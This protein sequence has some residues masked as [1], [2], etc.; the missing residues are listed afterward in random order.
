MA[1]GTPY[2]LG[3]ANA[4][5]GSATLQLTVTATS[6]QGDA[7]V[8]AAAINSA[9]AQ[10]SPSACVDSQG[11][12][13]ALAVTTGLTTS[14]QTTLFVATENST[15]GLTEVLASGTD[16]IT[17]T[18]STSTAA[19]GRNIAAMGCSGVAAGPASSTADQTA[20]NNGGSAGSTTPAATLP[21]TAES[22]ELVVCAVSAHD[23]ANSITW[24]SPLANVTAPVVNA[25]NEY[26][27]VSAAVSTTAASTAY[28][29]TIITGKWDCALVSLIPLAASPAATLVLPPGF[30]SPAAFAFAPG[31]VLPSAPQNVNDAPV[32]NAPYVIGQANSGAITVNTITVK[33]QTPMNPGDSIVVTGGG[34][35]G[36][37]DGFSSVTDTKGNTYTRYAELANANA[38]Q[39]IAVNATPLGQ[40][41]TITCN[42]VRTEYKM[43]VVVG[44][45]QAL[46][47]GVYPVL[48]SQFGQGSNTAIFAQ[49][50]TPAGS[51]FPQVAVACMTWNLATNVTWNWPPNWTPILSL[52]N[53]AE[54]YGYS[55]AYLLIPNASTSVHLYGTYAGAGNVGAIVSYFT[56]ETRL[57][58][59]PGQPQPALGGPP[60]AA[61]G[62]LSP[63]V[64]SN[65]IPAGPQAVNDP[66]YLSPPYVLANSGMAGGGGTHTIPVT[67]T[68][69]TG[70][71]IVVFAVGYSTSNALTSISDSN[72]NMYVAVSSQAATGVRGKVFVAVNPAP[73]NQTDT[74]TVTWA[75]GVCA[76][77]MAVGLPAVNPSGNGPGGILIPDFAAN[78]SFTGTILDGFVTAAELSTVPEIILCYQGAFPT[79]SAGLLTMNTPSLSVAA[80]A[81]GTVAAG[82]QASAILGYQVVQT[83]KANSG[84]VYAYNT[85]MP[86]APTASCVFVVTFM[87]ETRY[88]ASPG[89]PALPGGAPLAAPGYLSP[90]AWDFAPAAPQAVNDAPYLGSPYVIGVS[91]PT[92]GGVTS[93]TVPSDVIT[94]TGDAIIVLTGYQGG[95]TQPVSVTDTQDN[96]YNLAQFVAGFR[97]L[98]ICV[99]SNPNP[100][101]VSDSV[102]VTWADSFTRTVTVVGVPS[103]GLGVSTYLIED[104]TGN[105]GVNATTMRTN[106]PLRTLTP[107]GTPEIA[108]AIANT[109]SVFPTAWSPPWTVLS[110]V[111]QQAGNIT[112]STVAWMPVTAIDAIAVNTTSAAAVA[113]CMIIMLGPETRFAPGK[114]WPD[115]PP[116]MLAPGAAWQLTPVLAGGNTAGVLPALGAAAGTVG[117]LTNQAGKELP[118]PAGT[119][120]TV[121]NVPARVFAAAAATT[122]KVARQAVRVLTVA[123]SATG[124]MS[125][126]AG[127]LIQ[128]SAGTTGA[129]SRGLAR[130]IG[131]TAA[132][133][134][135]AIYTFPVT[136]AAAAAM[137]ASIVI[138]VPRRLTVRLAGSPVARWIRGGPGGRWGRGPG[139]PSGPWNT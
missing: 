82:T 107:K 74:V 57:A 112:N 120:A 65:F 127:K 33:V 25:A 96:Q 133:A 24:T 114:T 4:G 12:V 91:S 68:G 14:Y 106:S 21:A 48:T 42:Y 101:G 88:A 108:V 102:T 2:S 55:A 3:T 93:V 122:A 78:S 124:A 97:C 116:G 86:A 27:F 32:P 16:T 28:G 9:A 5:S 11:N 1:V 134:A 90:A 125:R 22:G 6:A 132:T 95:S 35:G 98:A 44:V 71:T 109:A 121:T 59:T 117:E 34:V 39:A 64:L 110:T 30:Q 67:G 43:V 137:A 103:A 113:Q 49:L 126:Q 129:L 123:A 79:T 139:G 47:G 8:V 23:T 10:A 38:F 63:P 131:V 76:N 118:A 77:I 94:G 75:A 51:G 19:V 13:Y 41:D 18:W 62:Y 138:T 87:A 52:S 111:Y 15:G 73:L 85:L 130:L 29:G 99:A 54:G 83:R 53:P 58:L 66:A 89:M 37:P 7:L 105:A 36:S 104:V 128:A 40:S 69:N 72:N 135:A 17:V 50:Q 61:P 119:S 115:T 136:L 70:D 56:G 46:T 92:V 31:G 81:S 26:T 60:L 20:A 100:L 80:T 45:P 84:V